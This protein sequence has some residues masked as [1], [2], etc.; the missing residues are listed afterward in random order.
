MFR[1]LM[2]SLALY[3]LFVIPAGLIASSQAEAP[4]SAT[5]T[6]EHLSSAAV[7]LDLGG[8]GHCSAAKIAPR[9]FL[10][11]GHC[12]RQWP[13]YMAL[14]WGEYTASVQSVLVS[15]QPK[16]GG[17]HNEDWAVLF[18]KY[19]NPAIKA[20]E[21]NCS[22]APYLGQPVAY[23]GYPNVLNLTFGVGNVTSTDPTRTGDGES[24]FWVNIPA[25]G[26][27]SGSALVDRSTNK[28]IGIMIEMLGE[29]MTG[30]QDIRDTDM[31]ETIPAWVSPK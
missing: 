20:L 5:G 21:L 26:G 16:D 8:I 31:C 7:Y 15:R 4:E 19:E 30:V 11:A 23:V 24:D 18:T 6:A 17:M 14:Q 13:T 12:V 10:T 1:G 22:G 3:A 28:V 27:A 2:V 25:A 9:T 29:F